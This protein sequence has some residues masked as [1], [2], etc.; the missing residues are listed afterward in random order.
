MY[1]SDEER[2]IT[3]LLW[4]YYILLRVSA[5]FLHV[6]RW[7][8]KINLCT[9]DFQRPNSFQ[10]GMS[11]W[12]HEEVKFIPCQIKFIIPFL[13]IHSHLF[14]LIVHPC[15]NQNF[16]HPATIRSWLKNHFSLCKFHIFLSHLQSHN[17]W[18]NSFSSLTMLNYHIVLFL[19]LDKSCL[20]MQIFHLWSSTSLLYARVRLWGIH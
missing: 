17:P 9:S 4:W 2:P 15:W 8:H 20:I 6:R 11:Q 16:H 5:K 10:K 14:K 19:F 13:L 7:I 18:I 1:V 12:N 3:S